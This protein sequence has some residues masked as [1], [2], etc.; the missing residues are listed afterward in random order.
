M[1]TIRTTKMS[2][3]GQVVIPEEVRIELGLKPGENFVVVGRDDTV[4]LKKISAPRMQEF[5][6]LLREARRQA[7]AAGLKH[8]DVGKAIKRARRNMAG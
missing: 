5:G 3:K 7:K 2:T 1:K 4:I 6:P 8:S